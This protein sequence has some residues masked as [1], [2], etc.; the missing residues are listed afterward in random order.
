MRQSLL[1]VPFCLCAALAAAQAPLHFTPVLHQYTTAQGLPSNEVFAIEQDRQGYMWFGTNNGVCR[2]NGYTFERF[3]DTLQSNYTS[4]LS[5]NMMEDSC[6]RMWW[7]DFQGRVFYHENGRIIP[8]AHNDTLAK[9]K[10]KFDFIESL[11]VEGC[12]EQV[13]LNLRFFGIFHARA[14]GSWEMMPIPGHTTLLYHEIKGRHMEVHTSEGDRRH[15]AVYFQPYQVQSPNL[16]EGGEDW[17]GEFL[18]VLPIGNERHLVAFVSPDPNLFLFHRGILQKKIA[19]DLKATCAHTGPD[20]SLLLAHINRGGVRRYRSL[21][22]LEAGKPEL[23]FLE[24][25]SVNKIVRDREGA[26]WFSTQE[27]GVFYSPGLE[28]AVVRGLPGIEEEAVIGVVAAR[29]GILYAGTRSGRVFELDIRRMRGRDISPGNVYYLNTLYY[30]PETQLMI[31][32]GTRSAFFRQG[33]WFSD[34]FQLDN[35]IRAPLGGYRYVKVV[36]RDMWWSV[37]P[38]L[39]LLDIGKRREI[40]NYYHYNNHALEHRRPILRFF[41]IGLSADGVVYAGTRSGLW[42]INNDSLVRPEPMHP[43]FLHL[44]EDIVLMPDSSLALAIR[45]YGVAFWKPG[46][47]AP[48]RIIGYEQGL[49]F[50]RIPR[51]YLEP[52]GALWACTELGASR[53]SP[54]RHSIENYTLQTGLPSNHVHQ[55]AFSGGYYWFATA[56]GLARIQSRMAQA[57]MTPPIIEFL[58]VNGKRYPPNGVELPHDSTNISIEWTA[59]HYRSMGRISY[60]YRLGSGSR[61]EVWAQSMQRSVNFSGLLPGEYTFEVQAQNEGGEWSKS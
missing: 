41:S 20:G 5:M 54:D 39:F 6:G 7:A 49:A 47:G 15:L 28:T 11:V 16:Y 55:V 26:Y 25:L 27:Q 51:L 53:I 45:G 32:A 12:G 34:V 30:D 40:Y 1:F 36:G 35:Q 21:A 60:R 17:N 38:S 33:C 58:T 3:P 19:Y 61:N 2:F 57:Q 56:A 44:V 18:A 14:D 50:N 24:G 4:V 52:G 31:A 46:S 37:S 9:L 59:L 10:G 23:T 13:W 8:W 48:P 43:S 22:E 42:A 29:D